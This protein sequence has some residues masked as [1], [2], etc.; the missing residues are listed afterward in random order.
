MHSK[1]LFIDN[2]SDW[3]AVETVCKCFPQLDIIS[4]F[5]L[6]IEATFIIKSVNAI[7]TSTFVI[8]S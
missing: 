6:L 3:Q 2:R 8:S 1:N 5:A 4:P 7:D